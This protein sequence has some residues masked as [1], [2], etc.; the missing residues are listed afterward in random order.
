M[1]EE[2]LEEME[3]FVFFVSLEETVCCVGGGGA[4]VYSLLF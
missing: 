2:A 4:L 1:S 3:S